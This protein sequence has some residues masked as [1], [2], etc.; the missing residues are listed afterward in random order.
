M[1]LKVNLKSFRILCFVGGIWD[2]GT[3]FGV[4]ILDFVILEVLEFLDW[5]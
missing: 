2:L 4:W 5:P 1:N 3:G